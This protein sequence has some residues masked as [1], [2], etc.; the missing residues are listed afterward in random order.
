M[1]NVIMGGEISDISINRTLSF[2]KA[3]PLCSR[4]GI[5]FRIEE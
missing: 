5:I 2:S 1:I 3:T 4:K